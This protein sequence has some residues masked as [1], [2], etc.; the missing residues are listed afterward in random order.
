MLIELSDQLQA[1]A[2]EGN[3]LWRYVKE[4]EGI[5]RECRAHPDFNH[6]Y[7]LGRYDA[8]RINATLR[9]DLD[10]LRL[11]ILELER[12]QAR[13]TRAEQDYQCGG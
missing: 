1:L 3:V 9:K 2:S 10:Q 12:G 6:G 5:I 4:L 7:E 11:R 8:D 13:L